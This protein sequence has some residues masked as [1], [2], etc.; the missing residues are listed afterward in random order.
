MRVIAMVGSAFLV[1]AFVVLVLFVVIPDLIKKGQRDRKQREWNRAVLNA[2]WEPY[3]IGTGG[4]TKVGII[5]VA[6][7]SDQE[8][9]V[10]VSDWCVEFPSDEPD[11]NARRYDALD[12]A[13]RRCIALNEPIEERARRK[14]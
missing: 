4:V 10:E 2:L 1:A 5:R 3:S 9:T 8:E 13:Q 7:T 11:W 6:R 12:E 14:R